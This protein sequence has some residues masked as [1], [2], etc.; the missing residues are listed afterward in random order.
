MATGRTMAR[1]AKKFARHLARI[2]R[3]SA[4]M[5]GA[6]QLLQVKAPRQIFYK[7]ILGPFHLAQWPGTHI[8]VSLQVQ[9]A[10]REV[11]DDFRLPCG[12]ELRCLGDGVIDADKNLAVKASIAAGFV[13]VEGDDVRRTFVIE[14]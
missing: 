11:A 13:V 14:E 6:F 9:D 7:L 4:D 8:V 10:V 3:S 12:A 5:F 1:P 2:L